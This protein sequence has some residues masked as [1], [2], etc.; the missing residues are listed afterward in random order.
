MINVDLS[1]VKPSGNGDYKRLSPTGYV[2]RIKKVEN[3][4]AK[5]YL[6][7]YFDVAEGDE[8]GYAADIETSFGNWP[9]ACTLIRSY[10]TSALGMFKGFIE[11]VQK[12]N[13]GYTWNNDENTLVGKLVGI[14]LREEAYIGQDKTSG[15]D[16][17]KTRLAADC[18]TTI[19]KIREGA[20]RVRDRKPLSDEDLQKLTPFSDV[21][22]GYT[23]VTDEDLP[24]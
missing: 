11:T 13:N 23:D 16:T 21:P 8:A 17:E 20:F 3:N 6:K 9:R 7:I 4:D 14:V 15:L 10:K 24:F 12:S 5:E 19:D 22:A 2:C 1:N 18:T